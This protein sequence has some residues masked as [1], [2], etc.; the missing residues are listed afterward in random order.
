MAGRA[1]GMT[2]GFMADDAAKAEMIV[3]A[4]VDRART[5]QDDPGQVDEQGARDEAA[6]MVRGLDNAIAALQSARQ[7]VAYVAR[8]TA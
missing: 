1:M 7:F 3:D 5:L 6:A 4:V 8:E 2:F